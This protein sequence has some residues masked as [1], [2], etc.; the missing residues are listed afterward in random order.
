MDF[1]KKLERLDWIDM[2]LFATSATCVALPLSWADSLFP[3]TA[4]QTLLPLLAGMALLA[5]LT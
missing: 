4:W 5:V 3:W 1:G 2:L